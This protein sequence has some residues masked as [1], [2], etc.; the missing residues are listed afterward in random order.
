M[1]IKAE[2]IS[3][4]E[5]HSS[6][7]KNSDGTCQRWRANGQCKT[8]VTREREFKLPVKRGLREYSYITDYNAHEFHM[9]DEC[10]L[11]NK[12]QVKPWYDGLSYKEMCIL[13]DYLV[14]WGNHVAF[15]YVPG[16]PDRTCLSVASF[17]VELDKLADD[18]REAAKPDITGQKFSQIRG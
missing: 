14:A 4:K 9:P 6:V 16:T 2:A 11:H 1:I 5:F 13:Y 12:P 10:H 7:L 18:L 15:S 8:W 3:G 17:I